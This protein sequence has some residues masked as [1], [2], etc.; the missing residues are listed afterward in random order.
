MA[1]LDAVLFDAGGVLVV[2]DPAAIA[3]VLRRFGADP[4]PE[5]VVRA[6]YAGMRAQDAEADDHDDWDLYKIRLA[7]TAGVPADLA[8]DAAAAL[9]QVWS[10]YMW[11][12][13]LAESVAALSELHGLGTPIG[14]VSNANGQIAGM[15]AVQGVCQV[16]PGA[17]VPVSVIVDSE[18]VGVMKPDPEIFTFALD[19]LGIEPERV[20]YVGDSVRNDVRGAEAAGLVP[21]HLDPYDDHPDATHRRLRTLHDLLPL[22]SSS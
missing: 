11:R 15:L 14:V 9:T 4:R 10:P 17:G 1:L 8:V 2:P 7:M 21:L 19:V 5:D 22:V 20:G 16:G 13:P 12:H 18:V 6:H 3:P